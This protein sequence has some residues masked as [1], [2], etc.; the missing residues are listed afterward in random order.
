MHCARRELV[1]ANWSANFA[2]SLTD[3]EGRLRVREG[4][5]AQGPNLL[6][7]NGLWDLEVAHG[8]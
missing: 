8:S 6:A 4:R 7:L 2:L 3:A 5:I 1:L